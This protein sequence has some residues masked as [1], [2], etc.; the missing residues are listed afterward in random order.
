MKKIVWLVSAV[1]LLIGN[2]VLAQETDKTKIAVMDL[3]AQGGIEQT[4][5]ILLT[6]LICTEINQMGGYEVISRDDIQTMIQN[7]VDKQ[8]LGCD[9]TK[10]LVAIGG[11][12]GVSQLVAGNIGMVG[13]RYLINLKIDR[14]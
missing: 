7:E 14:Q 1:L 9:D 13:N 4:K 11:A 5:V 2:C 12:L 10:C 3:K 8:L 6:D